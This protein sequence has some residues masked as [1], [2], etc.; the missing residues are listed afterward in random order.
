[1]TAS[2]GRGGRPVVA[3]DGRAGSGK[4][5]LARGISRELGLPYVNTGLMYRALAARAIAD[6]VD[7]EDGDALAALTKVI[8]FSIGGESPGS[9]LIDDRPPGPELS[10]EEVEACV[11][12]VSR[13]PRVREVMRRLQR[14]LGRGGAIMEGR[15]IG[16]VVFPDA[17]V[18]IFLQTSLTE[19]VAR[20][21]E[22]R[23]GGEHLGGELAARDALDAR[24][25]PFV[26]PED[27][28]A[29]ENTSKAIEDVLAEALEIV[30]KK[31]G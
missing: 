4:S 3:I 31:L 26:P 25:N 23:G 5:T 7:A 28:V 24:V 20:R 11:S 1:M 10:S 18:K 21:I 12:Q 29:I 27:A 16:S 2:D 22:E 14:A 30:R 13:H 17:D 15:D 19:R 9:L 8:L 6:G